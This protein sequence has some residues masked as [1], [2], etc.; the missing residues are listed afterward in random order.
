MPDW[1]TDPRTIIAV[2]AAVGGIG[3]WVGQVN[4]DRKNFKEFMN[5][6]RGDIKEIR[7]KFD[8]IFSRISVFSES[9]SP[10]RLNER[11]RDAAKFLKAYEWA[12]KRAKE[13][14]PRAEG[15]KPYEIEMLSEEYVL[16]RQDMWPENADECAYEFGAPRES[17]SAVLRIVLRDELLKLM[18]LADQES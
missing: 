15:L 6:V 13:L 14:T 2:L 7:N 8:K 3:Y 1:I 10:V 5:E 9:S 4:S 16:E 18:G 17:L 12:S 11:G